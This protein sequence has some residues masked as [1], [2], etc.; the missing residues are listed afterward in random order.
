MDGTHFVAALQAGLSPIPVDTTSKRP[1][2][3]WKPFQETAAELLVCQEWDRAGHNIG[4]VCGGVSGRLMCVDIEA[5][6]MDGHGLSELARRLVGDTYRLLW[7]W[8]DGYSE[9]TPSGGMHI[10]VRLE[11]DGAIDGNA[12]LAS[13]PAGK[14]LI[15]TRAEGGYVIV[16]PSRNGVAGWEMMSGG[17][18][19]IA[20]ATLA[21][22]AAVCAVIA[23]FDA[24]PQRPAPVPQPVTPSIL[25]LG[26]GWIADVLAAMPPMET[27]LEDHGYVEVGRDAL[28]SLWTR[29]G[30][31]PRLGHSV[32]INAN[33]RL[34][35]FSSSLPL[36]AS[37]GANNTYDQVDVILA[38]RYGREPSLGERTAFME[39]RRDGGRTAAQHPGADRDAGA[40]PDD[41][42]V[43]AADPSMCLQP[44]FWE[45]TP[46]LSVIR[47][48]S[49][50]RGL[51]PD[52][53]I[54]AWLPGYAATIPMGMWVAGP[55]QRAP[56]NIFSVLVGQSGTG[57]TASMSLALD[58]LGWNVNNNRHVL[59]G[60][61]LRSGEGL[62]Q[63]AVIPRK[64]GDDD[65][66]PAYRNAVQIV[67][68]EGGV[69]GRQTERS[70]STMIPYLNTAWS[71][72]GTV[73]GA[74]A[75]ETFGFPANLVRI[76]AV[77]GVQYGAAGNLFEGEAARLGFPQR[78][79]YFGLAHPDLAAADVAKQT[80]QPAQPLEHPFWPHA[81]H[82]RTTL[83]DHPTDIEHEVRLW[84]RNKDHGNGIDD[85]YDGHKMNL[86]KRVSAVLALAHG[87]KTPNQQS[88]DLAKHI[89]ETSQKTRRQLLASLGDISRQR[90]RQRVEEAVMTADA[91]DDRWVIK[92]ATRI[93]RYI[94]ASETPCTKKSIRSKLASYEKRRLQEILDYAINR[95]WVIHREELYIPGGTTLL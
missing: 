30:K 49:M 7:S 13:D 95:G 79:L 87:W 60:Q 26:D 64:R 4:I 40:T 75:R 50:E 45:A 44:W 77:I 27:V 52:G 20:Y 12:K 78:L 48:A 84:T 65:G 66:P 18:D 2:V 82:A 62:V 25:R 14:T 29:P 68:D 9:S 15:E 63:L 85:P 17:F 94:Q 91:L 22:W 59:L 56:L 55:P 41:G 19:S 90:T 11:G 69:L 39:G 33:G 31:D 6:F 32:R 36:P 37:L 81:E 51:S 58:L 70:G 47:E 5:A 72:H 35:V 54:G 43:E 34:F 57:K 89:V 16:A 1:L 42:T 83:L 24:S 28:G 93:A 88:W 21:E 74:L 92:R 46:L 86:T 71:G 80:S 3:A 38:H 10:L 67:Y 76:C 8:I 23:T 61:S 53:V 73:G